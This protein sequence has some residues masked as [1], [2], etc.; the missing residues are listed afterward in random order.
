MMVLS[1]MT[2]IIYALILK[3]SIKYILHYIYYITKDLVVVSSK[4]LNEDKDEDFLLFSFVVITIL[5]PFQFDFIYFHISS[6][7]LFS[8]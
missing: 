3:S 5:H 8:K 4:F 2:L 6:D 7:L 1:L